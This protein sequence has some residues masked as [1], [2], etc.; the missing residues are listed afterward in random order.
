MLAPTRGTGARILRSAQNDKQEPGPANVPGSGIA[1]GT[2][3]PYSG[4][5]WGRRTSNA[6]PYKRGR[7]TSYLLLALVPCRS[8]RGVEGTVPTIVTCRLSILNSQL[9]TLN[10]QLSPVN[11]RSV[12]GV[13][14]TVPYKRHLSP[15]NSQFSILNSQFSTLTCQL[16]PVT[17]HLSLV[18][19]QLSLPPGR[20]HG[21]QRL[22]GW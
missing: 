10:S 8:V 12:R 22:Q 6:C 17:C 19:C 7:Y 21:S 20:G 16:S 2:A 18:T 13:E 14:G 15:I 3:A 9:S 4:C 5:G 11:C 1:P